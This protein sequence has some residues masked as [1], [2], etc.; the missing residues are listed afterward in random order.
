M[1]S[2]APRSKLMRSVPKRS[3]GARKNKLPAAV[4]VGNGPMLNDP[5]SPRALTKPWVIAPRKV[6][7]NTDPDAYV[8]TY[9]CDSGGTSA[10]MKQ[11]YVR[12][13]P[14]DRDVKYKCGGHHCEVP[15]AKAPVK[16]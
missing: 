10:I 2:T 1:V 15:P 8:N 7:I 5:I 9:F 13:D 6:H 12:P 11:H 14:E 3:P 4:V 16:K